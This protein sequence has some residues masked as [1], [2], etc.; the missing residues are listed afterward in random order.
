MSDRAA[1]NAARPAPGL[2]APTGLIV[3]IHVGLLASL[4]LAA[5]GALA[6][7]CEQE[8][9][10]GMQASFLFG[11]PGLLFTLIG[12]S[13]ATGSGRASPLLISDTVVAGTFWLA[14]IGSGPITWLAAAS[15]MLLALIG[16]VLT[17]SQVASHRVE[18]LVTIAV[19]VTVA[20]GIWA[21]V[22]SYLTG[23]AVLAA[24]AAALLAADGLI[25]SLWSRSRS[26]PMG[27]GAPRRSGRGPNVERALAERRS[28]IRPG[29]D[30][31]E[32]SDDGS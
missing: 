22:S 4:G 15:A 26:W 9:C 14:M 19:L 5:V 13:I 32:S 28:V 8:S 31:S 11:V 2:K 24:L 10:L 21:S 30:S 1:I 23:V 12:L 18:R 17:G 27:G 29:T 7:T 6:Q 25:G 16:M 3:I 20:F